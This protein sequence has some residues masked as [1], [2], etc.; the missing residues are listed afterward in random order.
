MKSLW[1]DP[2]G[3][4]FI[5]DYARLYAIDLWLEYRNFDVLT[6]LIKEHTLVVYSPAAVVGTPRPVVGTPRPVVDTRLPVGVGNH[7][8][9]VGSL[10]PAVPDI[11]AAGLGIQAA[12]PDIQAAG[13][14]IPGTPAADLGTPAASGPGTLG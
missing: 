6:S 8:Q 2:E 7:L 5:S 3:G 11:P 12:V 10:Q 9:V 14:G 4:N 13:L 1:L